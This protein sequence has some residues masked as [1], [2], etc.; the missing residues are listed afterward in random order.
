MDT[1]WFGLIWIVLIHILI[2]I[3]MKLNLKQRVFWIKII[4][5]I[6]ITQKAID[7]G[8]SWMQG[9]F[10][11]MPVEF[12][13][14]TYILFSLTYLFNIKF[15]KSF[16][17]FAAFLSGIGY[18]ITFP[19]LGT[20]FIEGNGLFITSLA[21]IN[22]SLLYLGAI[23]LM[24]NHLFEMESRKQILI[25]TVLVVAFSITMQYFINFDNRYLFIYMLLDGRI[26][27]NLFHNID[28]N[29][30]IYLPYNML[31]V[32][33]YLGVIS[34]FYRVNIKIYALKENEKYRVREKGVIQHE[35]TI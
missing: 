7:Y 21:L 3:L 18:L 31:I 34:I 4:S 9:D 15:L 1:L 33:I 8:S 5:F 26:L 32:S 23:I 25:M 29:G 19:F 6:L 13:A 11:K 10:T 2:I 24:K 14:I 12:S 28:I 17:T 35:H 20:V 27:Y 22:H 16:V 30:F